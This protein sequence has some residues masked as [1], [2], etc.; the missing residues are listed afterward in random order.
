MNRYSQR[1]LLGIALTMILLVVA[2]SYA[3]AQTTSS[4]ATL[5]VTAPGPAGAVRPEMDEFATV[6]L[7]DPWDMNQNT[8]LAYYRTES[9]IANGTFANGVYSGQ[10]MHG[11]GGERITLLTA[12][13]LNNAA[14]RIGKIGYNFPINADHY[15]YLTLRLYRSNTQCNSGL[16]QWFANDLY[17]PAVMGVSN[18]FLVSSGS[19]T[20]GWHTVVIDLATIGI[21]QGSKNWSGTIRELLIHPFAGPG[22]AGATLKLDWA[23]LTAADPRSARPYTI[24]WT[25]N[26]SG[27][28]VTLYASRNNKTLDDGDVVIATGQSASGGSHV[29]Q[30]GILAAGTYYIAASNSSGTAWS[31]G[32]LVINAPPQTAISQPSM[33]SGQEYAQSVPGNAWDM[34]DSSDLNDKL[35]FGWETCVSN[36][37]FSGGIYSAT[38]IKCSGST[39]HTDPRLILGHMNPPGAPD[40][41]INTNKYRYFSFRFWLSGQQNIHDG[42]VSRL[43]WWQE[44]GGGLPGE[45]TVMS[46]D[47]ILNEGWNVYK[48]DLWAADVVDESHPVQRTWRASAPNRLRFD[49][50]EMAVSLL[51]ATIKIDWI[52]LTAMDEVEVGDV[53]PIRFTVNSERAVDLTFYYDTD[54]NPGNGRIQMGTAAVPAAQAGGQEDSAGSVA[55]DNTG[56]ALN[57]FLPLIG[58]NFIT[59]NATDCYAWN[60]SGVA[61]GTYYVCVNSQ[62]A[63][64]TTYRCSEA[65]LVVK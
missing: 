6:V 10:M 13:A 1:L 3:L 16:V 59:C 40:P 54:T 44:S 50:T 61:P 15:R 63:Y 48:V 57:V 18:S 4:P 43:G 9:G 58:H 51:P 23:R 26:G 53:F 28:P 42:W 37:A 30:T 33:T 56:L 12:G 34:N 25:G 8:D 64:N 41:I 5:A 45:E 2:I 19:C 46:R 24:Q 47:I 14:M 39:T 27:G 29:F 65:P 20:A 60:T 7:G 36:P 31:S 35:P 17:T 22:A 11:N 55:V 49:P 62:D 32:P 21:Q 38:V 52:K